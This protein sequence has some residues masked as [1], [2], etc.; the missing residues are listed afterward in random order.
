[1]LFHH[2][3]DNHILW[4]P[5]QPILVVRSLRVSVLDPPKFGGVLSKA[6]CV[7]HDSF[8]RY[9]LPDQCRTSH[10]PKCCC[11][12]PSAGN[13]YQYF[14]WHDRADPSR[15]RALETVAFPPCKPSPLASQSSRISNWHL[16]RGQRA[17]WPYYSH[18]L[19]SVSWDKVVAGSFER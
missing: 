14:Q 10:A 17:A 4:L 5:E 1:M 18:F 7:H 6:V 19:D 3:L 9:R 15:W 11:S 2:R 13:L 12:A 8:A 16:L